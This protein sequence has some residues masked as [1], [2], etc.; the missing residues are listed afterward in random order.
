MH[1]HRTFFRF[2][3]KWKVPST[4]IISSITSIR[5]IVGMLKSLRKYL[6][7]L[8]ILIFLFKYNK[9]QCLAMRI[10]WLIQSTKELL[11]RK[12]NVVL[13]IIGEDFKLASLG[14]SSVHIHH[15]MVTTTK[16]EWFLV[17]THIL[18]MSK[19]HVSLSILYIYV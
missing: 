1:I 17:F 14:C 10:F 13:V 9:K 2:Q 5:I 8:S 4:S 6:F 12:R 3:S 7:I 11:F 19:G 18:C 16:G 15:L